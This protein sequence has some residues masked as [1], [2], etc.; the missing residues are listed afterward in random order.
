MFLVFTGRH[1]AF[2][3]I[4]EH[5]LS[6]DSYNVGNY[7]YNNEEYKIFKRYAPRTYLMTPFWNVKLMDFYFTIMGDLQQSCLPKEREGNQQN[8]SMKA[9]L[10]KQI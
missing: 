3:F 5:I 1:L 6:N 4:Y 2:L 8:Q 10:W 9:P 7:R